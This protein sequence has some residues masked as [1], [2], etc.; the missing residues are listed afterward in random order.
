MPCDRDAGPAG[1]IYCDY[2][3]LNRQGFL[4]IGMATS[5]SSLSVGFAASAHS[6]SISH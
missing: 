3:I 1:V 6:Q 2:L 4:Q 5:K